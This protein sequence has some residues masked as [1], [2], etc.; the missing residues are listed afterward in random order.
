MHGPVR[1]YRDQVR[2]VIRRD[3]D[4]ALEAGMA[5]SNGA[6]MKGDPTRYYASPNRSSHT[7]NA[8]PDSSIP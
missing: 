1:A 7:Q 8:M 4:R 2:S 6:G 5:A 3:L